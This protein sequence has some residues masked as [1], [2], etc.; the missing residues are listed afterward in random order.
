MLFGTFKSIFVIWWMSVSMVSATTQWSL[1]ID[2]GSSGTRMRI[3]R[4]DVIDGNDDLPTIE[5][6]LPENPTDQDKLVVTPGLSSFTENRTAAIDQIQGLVSEA[7]RW[8]PESEKKNTFI[9]LGATAGLRLVSI[10]DQNY[11][12][13]AV[14]SVLSDCPFQFISGD[15]RVLSGEEEATFGW[16]SANYIAGRF[17]DDNLDTVG[18][19][20]LGGAST[21]IAFEPKDQIME[22]QFSTKVGAKIY[23][24][25]ATSYLKYGNDQFKQLVAKEI[26]RLPNGG[27]GTSSDP[28]TTPCQCNNF[29]E[30][31]VVGTDSQET[32]FTGTGDWDAC[33]NITKH[34]LYPATPCFFEDPSTDCAINGKYMV[35]VS[36]T[37]LG[38]SSLFYT[39][40][41]LGLVGWGSSASVSL[42]TIEAT[43]REW[44]LEASNANS[45]SHAPDYC[46][47]SAYIVSLLHDAYGFDMADNTTVT[48]TRKLNGFDVDWTLGMVLYYEEALARPTSDDDGSNVSWS[49]IAV[50]AAMVVG[51]LLLVSVFVFVW[52]RCRNNSGDSSESKRRRGVEEALA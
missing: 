46:R 38:I 3:F 44:C 40:N 9:R 34:L 25:Y 41:G 19:M 12:I 32:Y 29:T 30:S 31:Y 8:V 13:D 26:I 20:D 27:S 35:D 18:L 4:Y 21:Q 33:R 17:Q 39:V 48:Y 43:G 24:I 16:L 1:V 10:R 45:S 28:Y 23:R 6:F 37:F 11:L 5:Q 49:G 52:K 14:V 22:E 15:A 50:G 47:N 51:C 2:A 7:A 36:G 42:D